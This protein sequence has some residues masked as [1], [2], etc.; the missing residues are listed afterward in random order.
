MT[1]FLN[2]KKISTVSHA[3]HS[4]DLATYDFWLLTTFKKI[5]EQRTNAGQVLLADI[6]EDVF[7]EN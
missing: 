3:S 5:R 2:R 6:P 4:P 7:Y 1:E